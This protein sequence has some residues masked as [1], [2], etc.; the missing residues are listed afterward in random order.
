MSPMRLSTFCAA[1]YAAFFGLNVQAADTPPK[2]VKAAFGNT[3]RT[4][5][6]DGRLQYIW[7]RPDGSWDA[8][9]R[10]GKPSSGKWTLKEEKL[11][12]KQVKPFAAPFKYCTR[13]P[14][15]GDVG[16]VWTSKDMAG[17]PIKL[18]LVKGIERPER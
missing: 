15:D 10:R 12:M 9:G 18:T 8:I 14:A 6:P 7:L 11:C 5:Y 13:I 1:A 17:E 4:T 2:G 3:I 16:I